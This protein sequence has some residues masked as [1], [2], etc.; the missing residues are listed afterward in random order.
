MEKIQ[1]MSFTI[2]IIFAVNAFIIKLNEESPRFGHQFSLVPERRGNDSISKSVWKNPHD[3][4]DAYVLSL[5]TEI[6]LCFIRGFI[7]HSII[8]G[9]GMYNQTCMIKELPKHCGMVDWS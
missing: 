9:P 5:L 3:Q 7:P 2:E 6:L 1:Q 8:L 4:V